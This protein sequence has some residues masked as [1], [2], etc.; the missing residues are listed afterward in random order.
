MYFSRLK[1]KPLINDFAYAGRVEPIQEKSSFEE[2]NKEE[3]QINTV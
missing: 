2:D 3:I 1:N